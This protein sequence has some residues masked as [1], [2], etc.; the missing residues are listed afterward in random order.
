MVISISI[1]LLVNL[2]SLTVFNFKTTAKP[3]TASLIL[4]T[5]GTVFLLLD[6]FDFFVRRYYLNKK[7]RELLNHRTEVLKKHYYLRKTND[8]DHIK[9]Q[10][11]ETQQQLLFNQKNRLFRL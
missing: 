4:V 10:I 8:L 7:L 3:R 2:C 5:A 11:A 1:Y 9:K 6:W